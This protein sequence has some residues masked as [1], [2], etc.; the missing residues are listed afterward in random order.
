MEQFSNRLN[1]KTGLD[2]LPNRLVS[3]GVLYNV[4]GDVF[5]NKARVLTSFYLIDPICLESNSPLKITEFGRALA[6]GFISRREFY[7]EI[8]RR[9]EYPH[10]A[11]D[12]N[13]EAWTRAGVR[14]K[15][16]AFFLKIL[17]ELYLLDGQ[18]YISTSELAEHAHPK[19]FMNLAPEIASSIHE[20]RMKDKT[21]ERTRSDKVDRK[22]N[23][24][25]AFMSISEFT[26]YRGST[27]CLNLMD[28][29][30]E[31]GT[32]FWESR[33]G[34]ERLSEIIQFIRGAEE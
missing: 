14:I 17:T 12:E 1:L 27:V 3:E 26:F 28:I 34:Q 20:H 22:I 4:E 7:E 33:N 25:L 29:H 30:R 6:L 15:P 32:L 10:P 31:E 19:P 13:W 11:Y 2:W 18:G 21:I 16:L 24:I 23:D 8:F 9:F 5:R